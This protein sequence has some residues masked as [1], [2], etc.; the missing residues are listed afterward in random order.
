MGDTTESVIFS[1]KVSITAEIIL[2]VDKT[3]VSLL[4]KI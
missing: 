3:D 4:T 2:S 1:V